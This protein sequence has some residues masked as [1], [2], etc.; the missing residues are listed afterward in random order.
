[1]ML[2]PAFKSAIFVRKLLPNFS[3][4]NLLGGTEHSA[5]DLPISAFHVS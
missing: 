4:T 1:M 3:G 5:N 2:S